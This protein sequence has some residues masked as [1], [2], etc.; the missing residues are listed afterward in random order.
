MPAFIP[1]LLRH[2][3][4]GFALAVG[5]MALLLGLDIAG[6]RTLMVNSP[7]GLLACAALTFVLG[8]SFASVQMSMAIMGLGEKP[9]QPRS[10]GPPLRLL[11]VL[12]RRRR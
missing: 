10:G 5:F 12:V 9:R 6:L 11:P 4:M 7:S 3:A 2:A 8:L 1:F